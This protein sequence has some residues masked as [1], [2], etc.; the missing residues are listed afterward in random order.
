MYLVRAHHKPAA[1]DRSRCRRSGRAAAGGALAAAFADLRGGEDDRHLDG[2][3][4]SSATTGRSYTRVSVHFSVS[5]SPGAGGT[6]HGAE[7]RAE[8]ASG[9]VQQCTADGRSS[10]AVH[11]LA[12]PWCK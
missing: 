9:S 2:W 4:V 8:G 3:L 10:R 7:G 6:V 5:A 1:P 12:P 11:S